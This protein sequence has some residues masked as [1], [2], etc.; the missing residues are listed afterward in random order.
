MEKREPALARFG[1]LIW[2]GIGI[3]LGATTIALAAY[4]VL[5]VIRQ[6]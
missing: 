4:Q 5:D 2:V 6:G 3:L 1:R